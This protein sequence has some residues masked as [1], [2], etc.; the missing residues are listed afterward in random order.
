MQQL[1]KNCEKAT[2]EQIKTLRHFS[3]WGGLGKAFN[4]H[5]IVY[6]LDNKSTAEQLR[7]LLGD[8]A[9]DSANGQTDMFSG[10]VRSKEDIINDVLKLINY[11]TEEK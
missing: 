9:K 10:C 1:I 6:G 2:S 4:E 3:S 5:V 11:G 8:D 7:E